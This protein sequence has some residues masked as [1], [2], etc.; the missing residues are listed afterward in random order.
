MCLAVCLCGSCFLVATRDRLLFI[1][2]DNFVGGG[3]VVGT[4]CM[5]ECLCVWTITAEVISRFH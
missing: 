4:V 1:I 5:S 3:H 2:S